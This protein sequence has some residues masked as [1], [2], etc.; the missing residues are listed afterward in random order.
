MFQY[1]PS[2]GLK[3]ITFD[4]KKFHCPDCAFTYYHNTASASGCIIQINEKPGANAAVN[5]PVMLLIRGKEPARGKLDFPGGF[6]D[7]GEGI[8][9]GLIRELREELGWEPPIPPGVPPENYF[10]LFASFPNTYPYRNIVYNTCDTF[11]TISVP[12]LK[13]K[14]LQ[15]EAAEITGIRFLKPEEIDPLDL[16]FDSTR[17]AMEAY[18]NFIR[19]YP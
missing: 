3:K 8:L 9:E 7:P 14:D 1:C 5:C 12:S 18:K 11:F 16:A 13:E 15:L 4:G 10:E 6:T 19:R 17:K 2:C